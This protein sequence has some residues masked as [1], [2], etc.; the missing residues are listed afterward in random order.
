LNARHLE[1]VAASVYG[2]LPFPPEDRGERE[3]IRMSEG[4]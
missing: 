2:I 4:K 1:A 3:A